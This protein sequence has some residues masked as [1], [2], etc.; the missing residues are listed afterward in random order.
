[1]NLHTG[2][3]LAV[4][5]SSI[6]RANTFPAVVFC[7]LQYACGIAWLTIMSSAV[8]LLFPMPSYLFT[9]EQI[10]LMSVDP[11]IGNL[12]GS[13]YGGI[14]GVDRFCSLHSVIRGPTSR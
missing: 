7:A 5:L 9:A 3:H 13:F 10:G 4:L 12:I 8:S 14:L 1:V 6:H 11:F 2:A